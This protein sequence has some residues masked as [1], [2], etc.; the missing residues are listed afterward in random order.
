MCIAEEEKKREGNAIT[1]SN[2]GCPAPIRG[3]TIANGVYV[4]MEETPSISIGGS[5][6]AARELGCV[7]WR[8]DTCGREKP[9]LNYRAHPGVLVFLKNLCVRVCVFF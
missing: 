1:P 2:G 4:R 7:S 3:V 9:R 5:A 8:S 6:A